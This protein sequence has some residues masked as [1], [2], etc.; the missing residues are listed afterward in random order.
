M[1]E[2]TALKL[3]GELAKLRQLGMMIAIDDVGKGHASLQNLVRLEV[4]TMKIDRTFISGLG[5]NPRDSAIVEA[6]IVLANRLEIDLVAEGI[7]TEDQLRLLRE[8]GCSLGQG[9]LFARPTVADVFEKSLA[10]AAK[11]DRR[12]CS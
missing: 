5:S 9:F 12:P 3:M 8:M 1:N 4:D 2:N 10:Q 6:L 7:E 11:V